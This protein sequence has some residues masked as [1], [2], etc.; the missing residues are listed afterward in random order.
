MKEFPEVRCLSTHDLNFPDKLKVSV[1]ETASCLPEIHV[2]LPWCRIVE[3]LN[4]LWQRDTL[5]QEKCL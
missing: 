3:S 5:E 2:L 4:Y 1:E